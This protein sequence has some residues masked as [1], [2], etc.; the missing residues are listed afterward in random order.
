MTSNMNDKLEFLP[1]FK[2][3]LLFFTQVWW[4]D[5]QT[6]HPT[7][8]NL[9]QRCYGAPNES[10]CYPSI[11]LLATTTI[12]TDKVTSSMARGRK[13]VFF[14]LF[15]LTNLKRSVGRK[16]QAEFGGEK[17]VTD[18]WSSTARIFVHVVFSNMVQLFV[19]IV[20]LCR[21]KAPSIG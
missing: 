12:K 17:D 20:M 14:F 1:D 19:C 13:S 3:F 15:Q 10:L 7:D 5:G 4:T 8:S 16:N 2:H 11:K 6:N 21:T 9:L 18:T